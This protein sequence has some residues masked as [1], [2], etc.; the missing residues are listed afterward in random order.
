M[1]PPSEA[2]PGFLPPPPPSTP[3][4]T[5]SERPDRTRAPETEQDATI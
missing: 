5:S 4:T 2:G 1:T 3:T